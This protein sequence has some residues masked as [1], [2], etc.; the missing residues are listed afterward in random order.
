MI[1]SEVAPLLRE[2]WIDDPARAEAEVRNLR[3]TL[4]PVA[5]VYHLLC[6]AW[7]VPLSRDHVRLSAV[8]FLS[9]PD[10]FAA[11]LIRGTER[12]LKR[13]PDRG[14]TARVEESPRPRGRIDI[15]ATAKRTAS[16]GRRSCVRPTN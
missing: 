13:G 14:Y 15:A 16:R 12:L 6:Y 2:Y 9:R 5:N 11:V 3:L 8:P 10:F 1:E 4:I 7:D